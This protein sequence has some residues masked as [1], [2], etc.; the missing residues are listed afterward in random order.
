MLLKPCRHPFGFT[1]LNFASQVRQKSKGTPHVFKS[2]YPWRTVDEYANHVMENI[3][4]NNG[5]FNFISPS[6]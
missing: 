3:I 2:L 1:A 6:S 4:Y 5:T